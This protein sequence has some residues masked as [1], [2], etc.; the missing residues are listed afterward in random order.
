MSKIAFLFPGQ[1]SQYVGMAKDFFQGSLKAKEIIEAANELLGFELSTA[2]FEGPVDFLKQTEITQP[3]IFLHSFVVFSLLNNNLKPQV[4]AGHSLGEYTALTAAGALTFEEGLKLVRYRGK[5][6]QEAGNINQGTMAAVIGLSSETVQNICSEASEHGIVQ[7]ANFNSPG[8]VVISG[9]VNGVKQA[10]KLAKEKGAKIVKELVVS[11]AFH[12]PLMKSAEEKL[13]QKLNEVKFKNLKTPVYSN[14][15]AMEISSPQEAKTL[16]IKQLTS[17]VRWQEIIQNMAENGVD[18][19]VE[20][21]PGKVLQGLVKR[22]LPG[23]KFYGIDKL[24][25]LEK[26]S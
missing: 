5:L 11:G 2:M 10:M 25:E 22:I 19:F 14:V 17:P 13:A 20:I 12:S 8:Q 1:G 7:C 9:T 18:E 16:L 23:S 26:F 3:A 6:M 24:E 4:A 15:T 21:G